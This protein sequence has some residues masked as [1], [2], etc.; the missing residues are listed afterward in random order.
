MEGLNLHHV[1]LSKASDFPFEVF[2]LK[3]R[4]IVAA[5]V[6]V[7]EGVVVWTGQKCFVWGLWTDNL[8][9][10]TGS[11]GSLSGGWGTLFGLR[12]LLW[13]TTN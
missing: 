12:T 5:D 3:F 11:I 4:V 6:G 8:N 1:L 9:W 7:I 13:G 2:I 10:M